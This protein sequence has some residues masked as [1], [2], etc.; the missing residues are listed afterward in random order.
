MFQTDDGPRIHAIRDVSLR[1]SEGEFVWV[2]G[3]SGS[4]KST[5][6]RVIGCLDQSTDGTYRYAGST[7][8]SIDSDAITDLRRDEFGFVFQAF[9]LLE[10]ATGRENVELPATYTDLAG[11]SRRRRARELLESVGVGQRSE[12]LPAEMSGGEQQRVA[13]ARALTNGARTI[14]ADEPTGALD[15]QNGDAVMKLL[16]D[17]ARHGRTVV[18][19]SHDSIAAMYATRRIVLRDGQIA[20]DSRTADRPSSVPALRPRDHSSPARALRAVAA[21]LRA[22]F[23][24]MRHAL[25]RSAF[26][27]FSVTLGIASAVVSLG[28]AQGTYVVAGQAMGRMG[29]DRISVSDPTAL[30][31]PSDFSVD[32]ARAMENE[33]ANVSRAFAARHRSATVSRDGHNVE[34]VGVYAA[35]TTALPHFM[36]E[37]YELDQGTYLTEADSTN[38][39]QVAVI[40]AGLHRGLYRAGDDPVADTILIDGMPFTVKGVLAPHRI[41]AGPLYTPE[42]TNQM[43][44]FVYIP[45]ESAAG[46]FPDNAPVMIRAFLV[47]PSRAEETAGDIVDLLF[48]RH[49]RSNFSLLV[50]GE[51]VRAYWDMI[52][53][54]YAVLVG[55]GAIALAVGGLGVLVAMLLSVGQRKSE[56]AVRMMVGARRRDI[57]RQFLVEALVVATAGAAIGTPIAFLAGPSIGA[58]FEAPWVYAPW[59]LPA[60]L[61]LAIAMAVVSTV[62]PAARASRTNLAFALA[63]D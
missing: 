38:A 1:I 2:S 13:I 59:F 32:D 48:R 5:L 51:R 12:H 56:V 21:A 31:S 52:A 27:V 53:L 62:L 10:W 39:K 41:A 17:L 18:V 33:L 35:G 46:L 3:P 44:T 57:V 9:N 55:V 28:L 16:A 29:A 36:Y 49:G 61:G 7:V 45:F 54:E 47:D 11:K 6:L 4:G 15:S 8:P 43:E 14:L 20:S 58:V 19:A 26:S 60:A 63:A 34:G 40:G 42:R 50:H 30:M 24:S 23:G 22:T 25:L 37:A